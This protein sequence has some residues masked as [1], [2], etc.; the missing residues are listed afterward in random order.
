[1]PR[2]EFEEYFAELTRKLDALEAE[3]A[4][5]EVADHFEDLKRQIKVL[6]EAMRENHLLLETVLENS[7]A[8]IYAKRKDGRYTYLNHEME[9]LCNVVREQVLG[10]TDFEVFP[11]EIAQQWRTNDLKAMATGKLTVAEEAIDS[12]RG[13]RLVLSK[14][15]P[16]ISASGEVE[17]ICGISTDITDLRRTELAL[18]EAVAKLERERDNKL[19]NVEA[20]MAAIAHEVRQP[21]MAIAI[22]GSAARRF[23]ARV[24]ADI[25]EVAANLDRIIKDSRR[26]SEVFDSILAL[27]RREDQERQPINVN[28]VALE[29]LQSSRGELDEHR[30]TTRTELASELPLISGHKGQLQQVISNLVQNA[31]EA[32]DST[33]DRDR[34][35]RV[36]TGLQNSDAI[37]FAVEDS[38]PGFDPKQLSRIFDAFFTTKSHGVGLGLAIC[39][40]IVQRHGGQLTAAS[41]GNN[42]ARFQ[43]VLPTEFADAAHAN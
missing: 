42:G 10:K 40:M 34:V 22:N 9:A 37:V 29:V 39:R 35:L 17:G 1:M 5:T 32:M 4:A 16:L 3:V 6:Y 7:A 20:I 28:E 12:P 26:A 13:E 30:V 2:S 33:T 41:D 18:R 21:L 23:L 14:K 43:F 27:F 36:R 19:T 8:S 11:R 38:G 24:P 31:I 15:V 25:D